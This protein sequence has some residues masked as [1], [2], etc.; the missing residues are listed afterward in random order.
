MTWTSWLDPSGLLLGEQAPLPLDRPFTLSQAAADGVSRH[1]VAALERQGLVR[2]VLQGVYAASQ[3]PDSVLVRAQALHLVLSDKALICDQTAAWLHGIPVLRRGSHLV[4][5]PID[6]CKVTDSRVVRPGI[7]GKRRSTLLP[8]DIEE[9]H[10]LRVTSAMR[11]ALDLGRRL[12][13]YDA[14]AAIDGA[15]RV[16]VDHAQ[17]LDEVPRFKGQRGVVQLRELSPLGDGRADRPG[18]SALRLRW[19]EAA[20]PAPEPQFQIVDQWGELIYQLDVPLPELEFAAE[21]DGEENHSSSE[22][23]RHDADRRKD[24]WERFGW[25][26]RGF[27]KD[28]VYDMKSDLNFQ[29]LE[30]FRRARRRYRRWSP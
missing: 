3:C 14:L 4:A 26:V 1:Q 12:W 27:R 5:P 23:R 13:R 28:D 15:L 24:L 17:L 11:T 18:E 8:R 9:V 7:L 30:M 19:Y 20:L 22:D 16:G 2:R 10:G 25:E 6:T 29:L 21:Y